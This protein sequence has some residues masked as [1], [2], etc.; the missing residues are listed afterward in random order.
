MSQKVD[1]LC[2]W[3]KVDL[4]GMGHVHTAIATAASVAMVFMMGIPKSGSSHAVFQHRYHI[5]W[6][7]KYRHK[8]RQGDLRLRIRDIIKQTC[9]ELGVSIIKGAQSHDHVHMFVAIPPKLSVSDVVRRIK[10]RSS[11]RIQREFGWVKQRY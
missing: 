11:H 9:G 3:T 1:P 4:P 8:I 2:I 7:T 10:G 5:V 6:A